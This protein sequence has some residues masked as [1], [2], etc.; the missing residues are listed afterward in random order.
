[1]IIISKD[2]HITS[3]S[4]SQVYAYTSLVNPCFQNSINVFNNLLIY[5]TIYKVIFMYE[6]HIM[7][8]YVKV[9]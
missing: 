7:N 2:L 4:V 1:M 9:T 6:T 3:F 5:S 8:A